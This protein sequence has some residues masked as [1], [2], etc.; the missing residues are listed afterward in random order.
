[1]PI[2]YRWE[3]SIEFGSNESL[4]DGQIRF[5]MQSNFYSLHEGLKILR[6]LSYTN[7][8]SELNGEGFEELASF[9][10][11]LSVTFSK[12]L[13][14]HSLYHWKLT[15]EP[16]LDQKIGFSSISE[17]KYQTF[18]TIRRPGILC[19]YYFKSST[20]ICTLLSTALYRE[21]GIAEG[22]PSKI[23]NQAVR[24]AVN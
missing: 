21:T 19:K 14:G 22:F 11:W 1:M 12:E 23:L 17:L 15:V 7:S 6:F 8:W 5:P 9:L 16:F 24:C 10:N 18:L 13:I 2:R 3:L 20:L 4:I